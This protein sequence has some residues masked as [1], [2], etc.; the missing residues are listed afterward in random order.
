MYLQKV[1]SKNLIIYSHLED[2]LRKYPDP[3]LDPLV[4]VIDPQIRIR[5]KNSWIRNT[6]YTCTV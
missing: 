1:I 2:H 4:T 5:T 3:D 6:G